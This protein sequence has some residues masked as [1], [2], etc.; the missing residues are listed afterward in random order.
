M[1]TRA[2]FLLSSGA[3]KVDDQSVALIDKLRERGLDVVHEQLENPAR[4][5]ALIHQHASSVD[6]VIVGGG[7]GTLSA[8]TQALVDT[9]LPLGIIPL[10]TANNLARTLDIP[11]SIDDALDIAAGESRRTID[12]GEVNG[13]RFLTTAS[14]GLS[15]AITEELTP[16]SKSR[17]GR[18]AYIASAILALKRAKPVHVSVRWPD[19]KL[20]VRAV[21]VVVGNGR[22]YGSA[23]PVAH[24]AAIDDQALDLYVIEAQHWWQLLSLA[25]ALKRGTHGQ[26]ETVHAARAPEF[27]ITTA[28]PCALDAD[29]ELIGQ[30]PARF[31][32]LPDALTVF[33]PRN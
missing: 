32:V 25:P 15:V 22:Y 24:D 14:F 3:R 26:R 13:H 18:L 2:L 1:S 6:R 11:E 17:W 9:A 4:A 31:R 33:A 21:Q 28:I 5:G 29:G 16:E 19:G 27:E 7:D 10:G 23:L 30:T 20:D 12:V 8:A